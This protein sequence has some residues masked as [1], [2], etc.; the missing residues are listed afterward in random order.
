MYCFL[1]MYRKV[2]VAGP[3][4]GTTIRLA[5]VAGPG[6]PKTETTWEWESKQTVDI[7]V[8]A[9]T[10]GGP[11]A[12]G[13]LRLVP[14]ASMNMLTVEMKREGWNLIGRKT[15]GLDTVGAE[16]AIL[17]HPLTGSSASKVVEAIRDRAE[18]CIQEERVR[19][20]DFEK[21]YRPA[22]QRRHHR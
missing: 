2:Q 13:A 9:A 19:S 22:F 4:V 8:V 10:P 7:E 1:Y 11:T 18:R 20:Q 14:N 17:T 12:Y 3:I 16:G 6:T 5:I 21:R 15:W